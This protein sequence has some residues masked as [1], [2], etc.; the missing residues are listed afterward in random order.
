VGNVEVEKTIVNKKTHSVAALTGK[1][2]KAFE[3]YRDKM[4]D[5]LDKKA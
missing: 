4:K 5:I 2:R 1:G 3:S